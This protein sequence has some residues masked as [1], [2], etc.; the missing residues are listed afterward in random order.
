MGWLCVTYLGWYNLHERFYLSAGFYLLLPDLYSSRVVLC[1][2]RWLCCTVREQSESKEGACVFVWHTYRSVRAYVCMRKET[3]LTACVYTRDSQRRMNVCVRV[4][5]CVHPSPQCNFYNISTSSFAISA[6]P[7]IF[8]TFVPPADNRYVRASSSN[9]KSPR[10]AF[11]HWTEQ[12]WAL[13]T[14][15]SLSS[16]E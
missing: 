7:K 4:C 3:N 5:V 6:A 2:I 16:A 12:K 14:K 1:V 10:S 9:L 11:I 15:F 8:N 13:Y